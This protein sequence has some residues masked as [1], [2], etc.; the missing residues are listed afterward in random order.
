MYKTLR[1]LICATT[2]LCLSQTTFAQNLGNTP[3]S[4]YGLGEINQNQGS[5]RNAGMANTGISAGNS[6]QVNTMNPAL[7]FYNNITVFDLGVSGQIKKLDN[8]EQSQ[9]DGTANL[10]SV[11]LAVPLSKRWSS[12]ISLRPYSS[13][14][15]DIRSNAPLASNPDA[16]VSER[17][18][19]SGDIS[20]I[21]FGHGVRIASGLT[22]GASA[23]YL[24]GNIVKESST[25][26]TDEAIPFMESEGVYY[27]NRTHYSGLLFKAGANY[28]KEL[29]EKL[30]LSA[31]AVYSLSADLEAERSTSYERRT[32]GGNILQDNLLPDSTTANVTVPSSFGVGLSLDNGS[33]LTVATDF[34]MQQWADF[35]GLD[36][37]SELENSFRFSV[38]AEYVPDI[39]SVSNYFKRITYRSGLYYGNTPYQIDGEQIK[40]MGLTAGLTLPL[41]RATLYDMYQLNT[42]FGIGQRGST[43]NG[44]IAEKYFQFSVGI[45]INSRWFIKRRIE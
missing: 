44:L 36:G 14:N 35:K 41:G 37:E 7:L 20:E 27:S 34:T 31:G 42:A 3:Y 40:D 13:V 11:T 9:L 8:G 23:S 32:L 6:Y 38:G 43:D 22:V 28:R 2:I 33:N 5:I 12:A 39:A 45:T 15:Y 24:F 26:I 21:S 17:Y 1:V 16:T 18:E 25:V 4:R 19:G 10:S 29:K 30:Y